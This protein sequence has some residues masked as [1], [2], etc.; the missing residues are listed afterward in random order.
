MNPEQTLRYSPSIPSTLDEGTRQILRQLIDRV[1]YLLT[2]KPSAGS[3][4]AKKTGPS[5]PS[6]MNVA[7]QAAQD[8]LTQQQTFVGFGQAQPI[9]ADQQIGGTTL[10]LTFSGAASS[11]TLTVTN[12]L[13]FRSAI[14][15]AAKAN[16]ALT[17]ATIPLAKI[18]PT[19]TD[20]SITVNAEGIVTAYVLPT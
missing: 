11:I 3:T 8:S 17:P 5:T 19:G 13:T 10:G 14:Q 12:A 6:G 16:P 9:S 1:N 18:T 7:I 20:G 2:L 15:A 4:L